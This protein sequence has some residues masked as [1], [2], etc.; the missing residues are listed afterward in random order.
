MSI[1]NSGGFVNYYLVHIPHPQR[2]DQEPYQAECEDIIEA[3]AMTPNEA[4]IFK[5]LWRTS[6]ARLGKAK[7]G[8]SELRSAQK[9][10][11]YANRIL[12]KEQLKLK[13]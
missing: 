13:P 4:N 11:H 12:R 3:L 8:A 1:E 7:E 6:N 2:P 5:E 10:V 9:Y